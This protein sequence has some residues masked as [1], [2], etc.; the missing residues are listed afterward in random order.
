MV[1]AARLASPSTTPDAM[2]RE[3][4]AANYPSCPR[5]NPIPNLSPTRGRFLRKSKGPR[6]CLAEAADIRNPIVSCPQRQQAR[7]QDACQDRHPGMSEARENCGEVLVPVL[8]GLARPGLL[9][10]VRR[11]R[12]NS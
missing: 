6:A 2:K 7:W 8:K 11:F 4:V 5:R 3:G 9:N 12:P 1:V 10:G